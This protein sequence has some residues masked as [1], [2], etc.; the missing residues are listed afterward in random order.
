MC[1]RVAPGLRSGAAG[2]GALVMLRFPPPPAVTRVSHTGRSSSTTEAGT[3]AAYRAAYEAGVRHVQVDVVAIAH[4]RLVSAHRIFGRDRG[5]ESSTLEQ[6]RSA[7]NDVASLDEIVAALPEACFN[8]EVKSRQTI[9]GLIA[10]I[11]RLGLRDRVAISSPFHLS[12]AAPLRQRPLPVRTAVARR[13]ARP[14]GRPNPWC[15]L[16]GRAALVVCYPHQVAAAV[17][18]QA[19]LGRTHVAGQQPRDRG[20][21]HAL[22]Q[23]RRDHRRRPDPSPQTG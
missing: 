14:T 22:G 3:L 9:P 20:P 17:G 13:C 12:I 5:W 21:V 10:T 8:I 19:R 2:G 16:P 23:Q 1:G 11:D 7:G 15:G 4:G 6:L 18:H